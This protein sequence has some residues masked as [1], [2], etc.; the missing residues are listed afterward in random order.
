[1][2]LEFSN[3]Y[4][5]PVPRAPHTALFMTT[6]RAPPLPDLPDRPGLLPYGLDPEN[7]EME[8]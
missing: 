7:E 6:G 8:S 1:M 5:G 2:S 4:S 3:N